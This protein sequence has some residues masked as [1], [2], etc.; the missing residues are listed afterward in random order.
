MRITSK[1]DYQKYLQSEHWQ[2]TRKTALTDRNYRCEK[3][4]R[5]GPLHVH[6][7][8]YA[9]LGAERPEDLQVLCEQCHRW[10]H[11][12]MCR[13]EADLDKWLNDFKRG[14]A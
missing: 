2:N 11:F 9:N 1:M 10:E 8:T 4:G 7:L 12:P 5:R 14:I 6:H 13:I 3:C